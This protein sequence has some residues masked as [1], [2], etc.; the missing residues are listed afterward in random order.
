MPPAIQAVAEGRMYATVRN[1]SCRIHGGAIIAGVAAVNGREDRA[2]HPKEHRHRRAGRHQ[3][4]RRRHAMDG[5]SFPDL[6]ARRWREAGSRAAGH[7]ARGRLQILR[8]RRGLARC[9]LRPRGRRDPWSRRRERGRQIDADE[10]H[11]RRA[12]GLCRRIP[13]RRA[14]GPLPLDARCAR[15]R[16]R[17][18][19]SGTLSIAPDLSVAE[20][21]FLGSQPV[22]RPASCSG[23]AWRTRRAACSPDLASTSIP[24]RASAICRS[25]CSR[26]SRSRACCFRARASS[27]STSRPRRFVAARGRAPVRG[28]AALARRWAQHRLHLAFPRRHPARLRHRDGVPQRAH[29]RDDTGAPETTQSRPHRAHDRRRP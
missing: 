9:L 19:A 2:R 22:N 20:N 16:R 18:G 25:A 3:G 29:D 27:F 28:V 1:P 21:V 26:W 10:D 14:R 7:R 24:A 5:G 11:R 17:H 15:R 6:S 13:S 23:G 8:R 12:W 4:Q